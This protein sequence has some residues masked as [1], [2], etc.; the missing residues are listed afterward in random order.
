MI[1]FIES[2]HNNE[3]PRREGRVVLRWAYRREDPNNMKRSKSGEENPQTRRRKTLWSKN[4]LHERS[5]LHIFLRGFST[6]FEIPEAVYDTVT[7]ERG[8]LFEKL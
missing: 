6:A 4:V 2:E 5:R 7:I 1:T 8:T 3:G